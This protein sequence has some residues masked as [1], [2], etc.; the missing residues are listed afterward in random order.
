LACS[1]GHSKLLETIAFQIFVNWNMNRYLITAKV[2][3]N[4][5]PE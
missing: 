5:E 1:E 4:G 2:G 3:R